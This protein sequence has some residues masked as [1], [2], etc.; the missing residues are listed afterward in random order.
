MR[1]TAE[2]QTEMTVPSIRGFG[3]R[4]FFIHGVAG[5]RGV[6]PLLGLAAIKRALTPSESCPVV[7]LAGG[8]QGPGSVRLLDH[9]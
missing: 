3:E 5:L 7:G 1:T 9:L 4:V 2:K 8:P 6:R